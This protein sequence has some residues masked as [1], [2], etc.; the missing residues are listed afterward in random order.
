[1]IMLI[2]RS[3]RGYWVEQGV[4][5][6]TACT[7]LALEILQLAVEYRLPE[8]VRSQRVGTLKWIFHRLSFGGTIFLVARCFDPWGVQNILSMG[9]LEILADNTTSMVF[10]ALCAGMFLTL[11][12]GYRFMNRMP[13]VALFRAALGMSILTF[14]TANSIG[15]G[16]ILHEDKRILVTGVWLM[17]LAAIFST[18]IVVMN[19]A[20]YDLRI[21][22]YQLRDQTHDGAPEQISD[23]DEQGFMRALRAL[24]ILQIGASILAAI[25]VVAQLYVGVEKL[26]TDDSAYD[27]RDPHV[28]SFRA[29]SCFVYIQS[30]ALGLLVWHSWLPVSL[31]WDPHQ[32][33]VSLG[34]LSTLGRG[35]GGAGA[36]S[37]MDDSQDGSQDPYYRYQDEDDQQHLGPAV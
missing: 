14:I 1:M 19:W 15:I 8:E 23:A 9:T 26:S 29:S 13:P 3:D 4:L 6:I 37:T 34:G 20:V 28:Y 24:H 11:R 5:L 2:S 35:D 30:A 12:S 33:A 7:L 22:Y 36:D 16:V 21:K 18:G 32:R 10:S 27:T 17:Y 31:I 25:A